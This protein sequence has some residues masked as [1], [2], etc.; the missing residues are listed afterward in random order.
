M[1][2]E[3]CGR[4]VTTPFCPYCGKGI[5]SGNGLINFLTAEKVKLSQ[6]KDVI[7]KKMKDP[8]LPPPFRLR[9]ESQIKTLDSKIDRLSEWIDWA[10]ERISE[11]K[12]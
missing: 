11:K 4:P 8:T 3:C 9:N 2:I 1:K 6:K 12:D 10:N 5:G 7:E